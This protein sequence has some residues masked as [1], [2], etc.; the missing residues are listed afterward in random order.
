M[1]PNGVLP[2]RHHS[3]NLLV[4]DNRK[5]D[6]QNPESSSLFARRSFTHA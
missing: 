6:T 4:T 1:R 3:R 2:R 5:G